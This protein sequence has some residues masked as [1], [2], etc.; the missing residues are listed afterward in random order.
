M[1]FYWASKSSQALATSAPDPVLIIGPAP[2]AERCT[3][4]EQP[5]ISWQPAATAALTPA[6]FIHFYIDIHIQFAYMYIHIYIHTYMYTY[7]YMYM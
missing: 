5:S 4:P 3:I 6:R 2:P 1:N 7:I